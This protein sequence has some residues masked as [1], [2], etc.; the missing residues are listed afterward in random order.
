MKHTIVIAI[1]LFVLCLDSSRA[2]Q[3]A[4]GATV[5]GVVQLDSL[6]LPRAKVELIADQHPAPAQVAT[7]G[8]D[9]RFS[10]SKVAYGDWKLKI[11]QSSGAASVYKVKVDSDNMAIS[12]INIDPKQK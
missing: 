1:A 6:A 2:Q 5:T 9:G 12:P 4:K 11:T 8:P 3:P 7:T 10:F